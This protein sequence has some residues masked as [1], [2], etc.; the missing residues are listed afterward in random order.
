VSRSWIFLAAL[1]VIPV[2][3]AEGIRGGEGPLQASASVDFSVRIPEV[4]R[5]S[6]VDH[7]AVI[8]ISSEDSARGEVEVTG[9]RILMVSNARSG[10]ALHTAL[11]AQFSDATIEGLSTSVRVNP[12]ASAILM[13]PMV[14]ERRPLA[15]AVRYRFRFPPG[16]SPGAYPWPLALAIARY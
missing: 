11:A 1:A 15:Q 14:G 2:H 10:F 12:G 5:L 13:R 6:L 7:P 4:M 16:L 9:A 8:H 3:A